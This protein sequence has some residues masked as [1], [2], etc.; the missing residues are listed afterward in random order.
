M[1]SRV[2]LLDPSATTID[3]RCW[4]ESSPPTLGSQI[5]PT[6]RMRPISATALDTTAPGGHPIRLCRRTNAAAARADAPISRPTGSMVVE[7]PLGVSPTGL[8]GP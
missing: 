2:H 1:N 3:V 8:V 7:R 6:L 5:D 4:R